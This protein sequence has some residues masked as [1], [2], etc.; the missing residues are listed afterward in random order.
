MN[1][2]ESILYKTHFT[3]MMPQRGYLNSVQP[4]VTVI[5][6]DLI[7]QE[8]FLLH[9]FAEE[10]ITHFFVKNGPI[11]INPYQKSFS[12]EVENKESFEYF[13]LCKFY[14]IKGGYKYKNNRS[15]FGEA[16]YKVKEIQF[17]KTIKN[18]KLLFEITPENS[19]TLKKLK[20]FVFAH[21][22]EINPMYNLHIYIEKSRSF[23][24]YN[25]KGYEHV[26]SYIDKKFKKL[27]L[28]GKLYKTRHG[29]RILLNDKFRDLSDKN[30]FD[31]LLK[32]MNSFMI[33]TA[34][35]DRYSSPELK[36]RTYVT[37]LTPKL[38]NY[39]YFDN[40]YKT[41]LE[42]LETT[43]LEA[44]RFE[45]NIIPIKY[46]FEKVTYSNEQESEFLNSSLDLLKK[47]IFNYFKNDKFAVCS[48]IKSYNYGGE[49]E[50]I[51]NFIE[52]HDKWTKAHYNNTTLI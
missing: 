2:I 11:K 28:S 16:N 52:Y 19:K 24:M 41:I 46:D 48:F 3:N 6:I 39:E 34:L 44:L 30:N 21:P 29:L 13:N 40:S 9:K 23:K 7:Y 38:K 36:F 45:K 25:E 47:M 8:N 18:N 22:N 4:L 26:L 33:D 27:K 12:I 20:S 42:N 35:I 51:N 31:S 5:D 17:K 43:N 49:N 32:L 15:S 14:I 1:E 10:D 37:R 50:I